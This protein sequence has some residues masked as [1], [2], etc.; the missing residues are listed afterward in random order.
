MVNRVPCGHWN[1]S[2]LIAALHHDRVDVPRVFGG[3]VNGEVFLAWLTREQVPTL[4]ASDLVVVDH[5]NVP[6]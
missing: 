4:R 2:T 3:P 6:V 5:R 1:T